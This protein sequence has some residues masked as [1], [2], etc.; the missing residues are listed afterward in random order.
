MV[1]IVGGGGQ[2]DSAWLLTCR[3]A[4]NNDAGGHA[5]SLAGNEERGRGEKVAAAPSAA[6]AL[7]N[8]AAGVIHVNL[9]A[10]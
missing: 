3:S 7:C 4:N 2:Y 1:I 10:W 6:P 8:G 9:S 5:L